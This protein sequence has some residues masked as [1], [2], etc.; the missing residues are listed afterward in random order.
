MVMKRE[1]FLSYFLCAAV[2]SA[3]KSNCIFWISSGKDKRSTLRGIFKP[4]TTHH[5]AHSFTICR[6]CQ[7]NRFPDQS[8]LLGYFGL[9]C[10]IVFVA[11]SPAS[12]LLRPNQTEASFGESDSKRLNGSV[13]ADALSIAIS[14]FAKISSKNCFMCCQER[15]AAGSL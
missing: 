1:L 6:S 7:R 3:V 10:W 15:R 13:P 11:E 4:T 12:W 9:F 8:N 2:S 5:A 14:Y